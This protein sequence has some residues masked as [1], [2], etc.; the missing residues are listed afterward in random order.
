MKTNTKVNVKIEA[1]VKAKVK[2]K[3][4]MKMKPKVEG[5]MNL[6]AKVIALYMHGLVQARRS[7]SVTLR[8]HGSFHFYTNSNFCLPCAAFAL[9]RHG[10]AQAL[11]CASILCFVFLQNRNLLRAIIG[12]CLLCLVQAS[13]S[14]TV[15]CARVAFSKIC[16]V[17]AFSLCRRCFVQALPCTSMA[18]RMLVLF[19]HCLVQ[20]CS[21]MIKT[22]AHRI[23]SMALSRC[24]AQEIALFKQMPC[25]SIFLQACYSAL[26]GRNL[27][28]CAD[29]N[30]FAEVSSDS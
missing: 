27:V 10:L 21:N 14:Q 19:R 30:N 5:G 1:Q 11:P 12:L 3:L 28:R 24:L 6:R 7:A 13:V 2:A 29:G 15:S 23:V 18:L 16:L 26:L 4:T 17:Q 9:C 20:A 22:K 25:S 8:R